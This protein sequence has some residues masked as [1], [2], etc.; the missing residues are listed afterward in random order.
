MAA[1]G[2]TIFLSHTQNHLVPILLVHSIIE[3]SVTKVSFSQGSTGKVSVC[4]TDITKINTTSADGRKLAPSRLILESSDR[5]VL[6]LF[7]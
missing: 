7:Q 4:E 5:S 1:E 3:I 6:H 2:E